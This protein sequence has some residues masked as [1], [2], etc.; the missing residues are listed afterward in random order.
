VPIP[1][2]GAN[3]ILIPGFHTNPQI[4]FLIDKITAQYEDEY[5]EIADTM[6]VCS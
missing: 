5:L 1:Q 2:T 6:K 4:E 3:D